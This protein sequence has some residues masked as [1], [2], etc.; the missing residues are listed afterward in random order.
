ME[1]L[2]GKSLAV[3]VEVLLVSLISSC[4][5]WR[6]SGH[7][8]SA[9]EG[10]GCSQSHDDGDDV[11]V[12]VARLA[13]CIH[14]VPVGRRGVVGWRSCLGVASDVRSGSPLLHRLLIGLLAG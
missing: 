4:S 12:V 5:F 7:V 14:K 3:K 6:S 1:I 11:V 2:R 10:A 8:L 13:Q 9:R